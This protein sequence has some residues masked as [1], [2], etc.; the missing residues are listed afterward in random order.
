VTRHLDV[1]LRVDARLERAGVTWALTGSLGHALQGVPVDVNDVDLQTDEAGA[2]L[3]ERC[4]AEHVLRPV[5]HA[6]GERIR[7]H[8]GAFSLGGIKVEIMGAVQTLQHDGSWE[9][10]VDVR[11][12]RTRVTV[13]GRSIPVMTLE[14]ES[15]AYDALGRRERAELIRRR[16]LEAAGRPLPRRRSP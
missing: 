8:F 3:A 2:Y 10:V 12:H 4:F 16:L 5:R 11:D 13:R 7:S 14:Y 6:T 15:R 1:L 9:P